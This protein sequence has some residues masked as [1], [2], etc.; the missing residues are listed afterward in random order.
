MGVSVRALS[1]GISLALAVAVPAAA[2][3]PTTAEELFQS[4]VALMDSKRFAEAC[5]KLE[6]SQR[7]EPRGGTLDALGDCYERSGRLASALKA[8]RQALSRATAGNKAELARVISAKMATVDKRAPRLAIVVSPGDA[9]VD[10]LRVTVDDAAMAPPDL[11][12]PIPVDP[13][14]HEVRAAASGRA[15]WSTFVEAHEGQLA[16]VQIPSFRRE[17]DAPVSV[18]AARPAVDQPAPAA[19]PRETAGKVLL[20]AGIVGLGVGIVYARARA[21]HLDEKRDRCP[22]ADVCPDHAGALRAREDAAASGRLAAVS[23]VA[24]AGALTAGA[25]LLWWPRPQPARSAWRIAA[26]RDAATVE[27]RGA[28]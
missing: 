23:F 17:A 15:P 19:G 25:V 4:G 24:G 27:V 13:G 6:E 12:T 2:G 10:G 16:T 1:L 21:T 26:T 28:W 5:P 14:R 7:L 8:Y 18:Q 11:V 9:G 3:D 22:S 20:A